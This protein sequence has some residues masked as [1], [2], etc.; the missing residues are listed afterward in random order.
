M[1]EEIKSKKNKIDWDLYNKK[2]PSCKS[3]DIER[4]N[5]FKREW[6]YKESYKNGGKW[7]LKERQKILCKICGNSWWS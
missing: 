5:T 4:Q 1:T 7:E 2:C 6:V 3:T